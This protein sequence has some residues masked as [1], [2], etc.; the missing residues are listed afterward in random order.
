MR[1]YAHRRKQNR[2]QFHGK[3]KTAKLERNLKLRKA[4]KIRQRKCRNESSRKLTRTVTNKTPMITQTKCVFWCWFFWYWHFAC[5]VQ[6][7]QLTLDLSSDWPVPCYC[8]YPFTL[9]SSVKPFP[10]ACDCNR[11][12]VKS[13]QIL[14]GHFFPSFSI[15]RLER[16]SSAMLSIPMVRMQ[17]FIQPELVFSCII[18]RWTPFLVLWCS[19]NSSF[20]CVFLNSNFPKKPTETKNCFNNFSKTRFQI[21][22]KNTQHK[23][24]LLK[25][26]KN[27]PFVKRNQIQSRL[28]N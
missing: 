25:W 22:K 11:S 7:H 17:F 24:M 9:F 14:Y 13:T 16:N 23:Y 20:L 3:K 1:A 4:K 12:Y 8:F 10:I 15:D 19:F 5:F 2:R 18:Y 28:F 21:W 27:E 6:I 26:T